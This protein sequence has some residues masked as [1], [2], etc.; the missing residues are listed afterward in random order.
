MIIKEINHD[1]VLSLL[2]DFSASIGAAELKEA[3]GYNWP[4]EAVAGERWWEVY[5]E[6]ARVGW[7]CIRKD[8]V[9][10]IVWCVSGV[11]NEYRGRGYCFEIIEKYCDV[12]FNK[13]DGIKAVY[14]TALETNTPIYK[15][16]EARNKSK[17]TVTELAGAID[18]TEHKEILFKITKEKWSLKCI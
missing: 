1:K 18:Y 16:W 3:Y 17:T 15:I 6:G 5:A 12:A 8:H 2:A 4:R 10:P 13:M 14:Y 11:F 9:F 7:F